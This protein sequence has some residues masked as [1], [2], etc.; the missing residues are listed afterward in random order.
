MEYV[1]LKMQ[2]S[3]YHVHSSCMRHACH[4]DGLRETA[5]FGAEADLRDA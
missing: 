3:I 4:T 1:L 5:W 2:N